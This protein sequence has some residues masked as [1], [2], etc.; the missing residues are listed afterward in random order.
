[1]AG[2]DVFWPI[3]AVILVSAVI[4]VASVAHSSMDSVGVPVANIAAQPPATTAAA[5]TIWVVQVSSHTT[6]SAAEAASD[7][8]VTNGY[9][10]HILNSSNY[11]PL[12]RGYFVVYLGPYPATSEGRSD[13]KRQQAK[14]PGALVRDLHPR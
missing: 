11:R 4:F 2:L 6:R 13:A 9:K 7:E 12:N 14:L 3:L 5:T 8:L 1:M 10:P